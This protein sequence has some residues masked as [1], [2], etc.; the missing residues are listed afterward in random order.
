MCPERHRQPQVHEQHG[1]LGDGSAQEN[2]APLHLGAADPHRELYTGTL[3]SEQFILLA[4]Q[5][6]VVIF[7]YG[8]APTDGPYRRY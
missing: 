2:P 7:N 8:F 1:Q 3:F 4:D 5:D 6:V